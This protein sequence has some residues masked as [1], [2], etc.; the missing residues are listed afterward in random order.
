M[1]DMES[2]EHSHTPYIVI[3]YHAIQQ[4]RHANN[5]K[6]PANFTEKESFKKTVKDMS[7]DIHKEQ[8]FETAGTRHS[9]SQN[10]CVYM[11]PPFSEIV[12]FK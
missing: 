8:N 6:L 5:G 1:T 9:R 10:P 7:R 3:L 4:W 2:H 11:Y 12:A